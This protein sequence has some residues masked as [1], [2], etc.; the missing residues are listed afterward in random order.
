MWAD[1]PMFDTVLMCEL[2]P[3]KTCTIT[4]HDHPGQTMSGE[5]VS[6]FFDDDGRHMIMHHVG[7]N[8][9][10][11]RIRDDQNYAAMNR[12]CI[13]EMNAMP[14][15]AGPVPGMQWGF[16]RWILH[17]LTGVTMSNLTFNVSIKI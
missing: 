4:T 2:G 15:F 1:K 13:I 16:R 9:F 5:T 11:V 3:G 17:A 10:G 12:P 7:I 14:R 6:E 8:P